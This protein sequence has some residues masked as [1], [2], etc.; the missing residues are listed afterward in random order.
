MNITEISRPSLLEVNSANVIFVEFA[1]PYLEAF[2]KETDEFLDILV[3]PT[4]IISEQKE[5]NKKFQL[6]I[7]QK[8]FDKERYYDFN[9]H[10][11][12]LGK[13]VRLAELNLDILR[14]FI[15]LY[16][17][18]NNFENVANR[19]SDCRKLNEYNISD[20][21]NKLTFGNLRNILSCIVKTDDF[22]H[23]IKGLETKD[24]RKIFTSIYKNFIDDRDNF[25]HGILFF[26][27]TN[28]EPILRVI[29]ENQSQY[30]TYSKEIFTDSLK[31]F[32][33]LTRIIS[34]MRFN[35]QEKYFG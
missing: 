3:A 33:Y 34:M 35:F 15:N 6:P 2:N 17:V 22:F 12:S 10:T 28:F 1:V 18:H 4:L 29:H 9:N 14:K 24:E 25:T 16:F 30:I 8:L 31:T 27:Y 26:Q 20:D 7:D 19:N 21:F 11:Y 23:S 32:Q 13:L 5:E